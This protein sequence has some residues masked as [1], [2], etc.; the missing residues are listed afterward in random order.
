[1][2]PRGFSSLIILLIVALVVAGG[3]YFYMSHQSPQTTVASSVATTTIASKLVTNPT[4]TTNMIQTSNASDQAVE[5]KPA[6]GL[7]AKIIDLSTPAPTTYTLTPEDL[8]EVKAAVSDT[9]AIFK[10][11]DATRIRATEISM[12][13]SL[14]AHVQSQSDADALN[15]ASFQA[16]LL[17]SFLGILDE[18]SLTD[19]NGK[20]IASKPTPTTLHI[21][22]QDPSETNPNIG[23][24]FKFIQQNG[25]WAMGS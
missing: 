7:P 12:N 5:S 16:D 6:T 18:P 2:K 17:T 13:S 21:L 1:M 8:L 22:V 10:S 25:K 3:A 9:M 20:A 4:T 11:G 24:V 19:S 23:F 15:A 14:T